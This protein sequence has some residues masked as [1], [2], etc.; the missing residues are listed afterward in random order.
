M[1]FWDD[2]IDIGENIIGGVG[3]FL[4]GSDAGNQIVSTGLD[5]L[6]PAVQ[7]W[8]YGNQDPRDFLTPEQLHAINLSNQAREFQLGQARGMAQYATPE[9]QEAIVRREAARHAYEAD[10]VRRRQVARG[11][12]SPFTSNY[13]DN[14][15]PIVRRAL[16]LSDPVSRA[17]NLRNQ[18]AATAAG[19]PAYVGPQNIGALAFGVDHA[20]QGQI[21][22]AAANILPAINVLFG[23]SGDGDGVSGFEDTSYGIGGGTGSPDN[24]YY[25]MLI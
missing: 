3:D 1:S 18:A 6:S 24:P 23:D 9:A 16:N 11:V 2:I 5:L 17:M 4:F 13:F 10:M 21:Q 25:G 22:N 15:D 7:E 20:R 19:V 14:I 8:I 12:R